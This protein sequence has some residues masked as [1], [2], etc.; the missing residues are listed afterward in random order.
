MM[1]TGAEVKRE[2][3]AIGFIKKALYSMSNEPCD[4]D[5]MRLT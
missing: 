2:R 3:A 1:L 5:A 4:L